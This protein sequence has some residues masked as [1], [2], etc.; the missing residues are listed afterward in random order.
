MNPGDN[1]RTSPETSPRIITE[2]M[3]N[4]TTPVIELFIHT[5]CSLPQF[6]V[7]LNLYLMPAPEAEDR[8]VAYS[9]SSHGMSQ[10]PCN[11]FP[12]SAFIMPLYLAYRS[13]WP[14]LAV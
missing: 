13:K 3:M 1:S 14:D 2:I 5:F 10:K 7:Y 6:F 9:A 12:F 8:L 4:Q 11:K